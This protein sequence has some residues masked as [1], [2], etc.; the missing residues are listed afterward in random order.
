MRIT[1]MMLLAV[2]LVSCGGNDRHNLHLAS[3]MLGHNPDSALILLNDIDYNSLSDDGL[4]ADYIYTKAW[5]HSGTGRSLVTDSLIGFAAD[6]YRQAG[7]TV[8]WTLS[9]RLL[10]AYLYIN[11][12]PDSAM[13]V[14]NDAISIV[15]QRDMLWELRWQRT[16]LAVDARRFDKA[17]A[18]LDWLIANSDS[19]RIKF[20][21]AHIRAVSYFFSNDYE[22][23][24]VYADSLMLSP[25][26]AA[27]TD[28][29]RQDFRCD[30]AE[31]LDAAGRSREAI[32]MLDG[33]VASHV[34]MNDYDRLNYYLSYAKF[35]ANVGD[36]ATSERYISYID[37]LDY[38]PDRLDFDVDEYVAMLKAS[39]DLKKGAPMVI[40]PMKRVY[41]RYYHERDKSRTAMQEVEILNRH[42]QELTI[43]RQ[44]LMIAVSAVVI[45]A[46]LL[47]GI[48]YFMWHRRRLRLIEA[49]ERVDA[50]TDM[51][52]A[53]DKTSGNDS[54]NAMLKDLVLR[55]IG[56]LKT[57]AG[58]PTA[59][60][61]DAL[62]K[63]S[64]VGKGSDAIGSLVDW[65]GVYA[66]IDE[67]YDGFYSGILRIHPDTFI[68]K[69]LQI[70]VLIRAGFSTKEI[71]VLTEQSSAT[72]YVRKTAIRKKLSAPENGDIIALLE[73]ELRR[74]VKIF[75]DIYN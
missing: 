53:L 70:I 37:S 46:L 30:Y 61:R 4:R 43:E 14:L 63:I 59:Q 32:R 57:F 64:S 72:I 65:P 10:A 25:L 51:L 49:E 15:T 74:Q 34:N 5:A 42:K 12:D 19:D 3:E 50:L 7:D 44:R 48:G 18:D 28:A 36:I 69:E 13:T 22:H 24:V 60:N 38:S 6:Y 2:I 9:T 8:K 52:S 58:A 66:M 33:V 71:G 62:R 68:E 27:Q 23:A 56:I 45:V 73:S 67:L 21:M 1:V 41:N 75:V 47:G 17:V 20:Q 29:D 39:I 55:Q 40:S 16:E 54:R 31:L 26:F 11:A 35:Y